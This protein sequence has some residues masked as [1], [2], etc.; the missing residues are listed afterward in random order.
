MTEPPSGTVTFLFTDLEGSTQLWE[1][2]PVA[3]R[4]AL[5]RHDSLVTGAIE[6]HD[7]YVVKS[8]GDGFLAAFA[9]A[10]EAV[11]AAIDAQLALTAEPWAETGPLRVRMGLHT[12]AAELRAGD[13]HGPTLNRAARLMSVGHG[14]Q[15]LLSL[16]TS[17]L[18]R[19]SDVDLLDLGSHRLRG[20]AEPEHVCQVVHPR[21][22]SEFPP[23]RSGSADRR[24]PPSN[25]PEPID[26]FVGRT[27]ERSDVRARLDGTR[28]LTLLGPGGTGKTRLALHVANDARDRFG[29][30]VY[31]IDLSAARDG[32]AVL[33]VI[34][35]TV[36]AHEPGDRPLLEAIE[37]QIGGR[38]MLLVV[39]NFEQVVTAASTL[40]EL[41]RACPGLTALVTSREALNVK[42]EQVY[43][44]SPLTLPDVAAPL[45]VDEL[46]R[47]EAVQLFLERAREVRADFRLTTEN[48]A[49]V[50]ELCV[51]VDGL[52]LAIELAAARLSMFSPQALLERLGNRLDLLNAGRR[53]APERQ[54][55]LRD[56]ISWSHELLT[57]DEQRLFA[58]LSVFSGATLEAVEGVTGRVTGYES[59]ATL[60]ALGSL[61]AKSLVRQADA[62]AT[63]PRLSMLD[64]IR[65]FAAE[66]LGEDPGLLGAVRRAHADY[67]AEWTMLQCEKLTGDDR[68][69]ASA[70]MAAD[71]QN[72]STAWRFWVAERDFEELGRLTDGLWLLYDARGWYHEA[73]TLITDLLDVLA[74]TSTTEELRVQQIL[75]QTSLA[76][77]L[78]AAKGFTPETEQAYE[79]ALELCAALGEVPQLLPVLRGLSTFLIYRAEFEKSMRVGEQLLALAERFDD[80]RARVEGHLLIGVS[81][82]ML[83]HLEPGIEHL[84][85]GIAAYEAAPRTVE[86]FAA[87]NDP[88]VV[89]HVVEGMLLWM[90]GFPDRARDRALESVA[91]AEQLH[92]PQSV[93]YAHF[94]T[95]LVHLWRRET[96]RA[97]AHAQAVT[98]LAA[99]HDFPVWAA[100]GGC[101]YGVAIAGSGSV[102][103][104]LTCLDAAMEQ[105]R[106]LKSP[107]VFWPALLQLRAQV[108]LPAGRAEEGLACVREALD[109]LAGLPEPQMMSSELMVLEGACR[110]AITT[111]PADAAGPLE[112]AVGCA[113]R[114][115]APMLQLRASVALARVRME[116]GRA[117]D[118][119]ALLSSAYDRFGE[120][121]ETLDLVEARRLLDELESPLG[122]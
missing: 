18:V 92:H 115:E 98:D 53:D 84:E 70:R 106:A 102:E 79:R 3:M 114:L 116:Q 99:A 100:A 111:D 45:S 33:G 103:E 9:D 41:L 71:I 54:R 4:S 77:V 40:T 48:A 39:D 82:G 64:T 1:E 49:A 24:P 36:G 63:S 10:A 55:T 22:A 43:P 11:S 94:H 118:A 26:R 51:R 68:E 97:A 16:V 73:A 90:K 76:R 87:G 72:L 28:L 23:L 112:R 67:F 105:Y 62:G 19:G 60:D 56:T 58:L 93:A 113:D 80:A 8:T 117:G 37:E 15:I 65:E 121:F 83:A 30:L 38:P 75:L 120:G 104:G 2:H 91:L 34:A 74:S 59:V 110:W 35:R 25:L 12:G 13:Y 108:L 6:V 95:G 7:G 107:P 21:L 69:D 5:A 14:G 61:V 47:C 88:G 32:D 96:E 20:L 52:P 50:A 66:R 119:R 85:A 17:E 29:D 109:I 42:G 78:M 27:R 122:G 57:R 44:L 81:E 86:R 89:C 101:L 31:L 46:S